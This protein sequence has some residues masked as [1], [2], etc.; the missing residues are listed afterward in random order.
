MKYNTRLGDEICERTATTSIG[1]RHIC[2]QLDLPYSTVTDW[3]YDEDH[4]LHDRYAH[5]KMIQLHRI[6]EEILEIADDSSNDYMTIVKNGKEVI[7]QNKESIARSRLR[8]QARIAIL[9]KLTPKTSKK[10]SARKIEEDDDEVQVINI[11]FDDNDKQRHNNHASRSARSTKEPTSIELN[12]VDGKGNPVEFPNSFAF[13]K[14]SQEKTSFSSPKND[15]KPA[16]EEAPHTDRYGVT[17]SYRT[18]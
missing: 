6:A 12:F 14:G 11:G 1:L 9:T 16:P 2:A 3:I 18:R 4:E 7:V 17:T 8:I 5:A 13:G 15:P 10:K